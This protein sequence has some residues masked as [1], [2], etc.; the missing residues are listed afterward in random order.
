V[1]LCRISFYSMIAWAA[2]TLL[3]NLGPVKE[4]GKSDRQRGYF[5]GGGVVKLQVPS[6]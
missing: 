6:R 2:G 3:G 1:H 4:N 5:G